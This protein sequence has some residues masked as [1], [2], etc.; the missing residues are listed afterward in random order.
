MA[1]TDAPSAT[2]A[3]DS[4]VSQVVTLVKLVVDQGRRLVLRTPISDTGFMNALGIL[5]IAGYSP[6]TIADAMQEEALAVRE[7]CAGRV[8]TELPP[9]SARQ[10]MLQSAYA[11][12]QNGILYLGDRY[13]PTTGSRIS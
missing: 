4:D 11:L 12:L 6:D 13:N 3:L 9:M 5:V 10:M 7:W 8:V 1:S 2:S